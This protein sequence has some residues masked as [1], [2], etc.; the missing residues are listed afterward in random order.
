[1]FLFRNDKKPLRNILTYYRGLEKWYRT[2]NYDEMKK[3]P[4]Y[5]DFEMLSEY[6]LGKYAI[7]I[8][9]MNLVFYFYILFN[10]LKLEYY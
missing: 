4:A 10:N 8:E 9:K 6:D 5:I 1:M 7:Q 3:D 2:S